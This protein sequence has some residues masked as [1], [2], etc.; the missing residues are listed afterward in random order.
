MRDP[1][2]YHGT[3]VLINNKN[4]RDQSL[5]DKIEIALTYKALSTGIP[6]G[7]FDFQHLKVIHKH[8]FGELY[9]WAGQTREVNIAKQSGMF[10]APG[11]IENEINKLFT[12]LA[13]DNYLKYFKEPK[14]FI[15]NFTH[16]F[17]E[18]NAIHPFREGNGRCTRAFF[19]QLA[20]YNGYKLDLQH[21]TEVEFIQ[22]CISSHNS[23][24]TKLET[25]FTKS[26]SPAL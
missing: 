10:C 13:K 9:P 12:Q 24:N 5:L 26:L 21:I 15:I 4:I 19:E 1:Y 11:F 3:T 6:S 2:V 17:A 7:N 18:V 16:Y 8:I 14:E 23:A 25:L 22:A 20:A